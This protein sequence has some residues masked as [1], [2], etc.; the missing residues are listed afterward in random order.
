ML[1]DFVRDNGIAS[2]REPIRHRREG[3]CGRKARGVELRG[4]PTRK[5]G[6]KSQN[7][8]T[9]NTRQWTNDDRRGVSAKV[10]FRCSSQ[11]ANPGILS[12]DAPG[13]AVLCMLVEDGPHLGSMK[14]GRR[15]R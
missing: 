11:L 2:N 15:E 4:G 13:A 5:E 1:T 14:N 7:P 3:V 8:V 6:G 10:C 9:Q 12:S